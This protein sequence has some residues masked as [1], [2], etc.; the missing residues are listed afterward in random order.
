MQNNSYPE[1]SVFREIVRHLHSVSQVAYLC[2]CACVRDQ[3]N[4]A[5]IGYTIFLTELV[6]FLQ[7]VNTRKPRIEMS[8]PLSL[9][10]VKGF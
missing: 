4:R 6:A 9:F 8:K 2:A 3:N 1:L 10:T 7:H 5:M